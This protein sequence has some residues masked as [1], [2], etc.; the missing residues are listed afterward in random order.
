MLSI[1]CIFEQYGWECAVKLK[2]CWIVDALVLSSSTVASPTP[3]TPLVVYPECIVPVLAQELK[4]CLSSHQLVRTSCPT[5]LVLSGTSCLGLL[6]AALQRCTVMCLC[7]S[8]D[9]RGGVIVYVCAHECMCVYAHACFCVCTYMYIHT[10][11]HMCV[12][13]YTR[14]ICMCVRVCAR[15]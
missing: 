1:Y 11:M 14:I 10:C 2:Q 15:M 5:K 9:S 6:V 12:H 3:L 8:W 7:Y 4:T 13:I